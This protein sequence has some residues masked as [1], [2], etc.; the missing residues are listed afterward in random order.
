MSDTVQA[1]V[2]WGA[3]VIGGLTGNP[4][5]MLWGASQFLGVGTKR[6]FEPGTAPTAAE[7]ERGRQLNVLSNEAS[8]P[9]VYGRTRAGVQII[10]VRLH[11]SDTNILYVVAALALGSED[12]SGIEDV[13]E[14]YFDER[15]AISN[16]VF[17]SE[18]A[19]TGVQAPFTGKLS[20]GLHR[21]ADAQ[22][23]DAELDSVFSDYDADTVGRGIAY[24][25]LKLTYDTAVYPTGIPN[26][27]AVVKGQRVWDP[28]GTPA[29]AHSDS[30]AL[31]ILDYLTS[32]RYG[33][34]VLYGERDG[35]ASE[36]D[37]QSF[38]DAA[39]Y[40][41]DTITMGPGTGTRFTCNGLVDTGKTHG[42]VLTELLSSCRSE[43]IYEGGKFRL[44]TPQVTSPETFELNASNI[45]GEI[46]YWRGGTEDVPNRVI[47]H[48]IDDA[49][50]WLPQEVAWPEANQANGFLTA[51][52]NFE[53]VLE[54]A[55]PFTVG[56]YRAQQIGMVLLREA[57]E[58][59]GIQLTTREEGLKLRVGEVVRVTQSRAGF[60]QK[61]F[62]VRA[63][64][65]NADN[66]TRLVLAEYD[67]AAYTLDAQNTRDTLPASS[68]PDPFTIAAPTS[69]SATSGEATLLI[70]QGGAYIPRIQL[71]W[72]PPSTPFLRYYEVQLAVASSGNWRD[73]GTP[74]GLDSVVLVDGV[75]EGTAYD[76][77]IRAVNALDI[78]SAW[79]TVSSHTV[80]KT[81]AGITTLADNSG[82]ELGDRNWSKESGWA[83]AD[84]AANARR[85]S[86]R[87]A[88]TGGTGALRNS[89]EFLVDISQS[90]LIE[91]WIKGTVGADGDARARI[92][93]L[94]AS[95]VE[96]G[97]SPYTSV[98]ADGNYQKSSKV[99]TPPAGAVYGRAEFAV[100]TRTTG[101][102]YA[103]D[104]FCQPVEI[105][106][107]WVQATLTRE[108]LSE[109]ATLTL[110]VTDP[111]G[112]ITA[113][114]F[115]KR[116]GSQDGDVFGAYS[117][118][119]DT[120]PGSG[121]VGTYEEDLS[122]PGGEESAIAWRATFTDEHGTSRTIGGTCYTSQIDE[123]EP[124]LI[125][126][127]PEFQ[128]LTENAFWNFATGH[129]TP[130]AVAVPAQM[131]A[132]VVLPEGVEITEFRVRGF[133]NDTGD[134]GV[135]ELRRVN[136]TGTST[137]L[138]TLTLTQGGGW[139]LL[140]DTSLA[141]VVASPNIYIITAHLDSDD[142]V[143]NSRL[144]YASLTY[145]RRTMRQVV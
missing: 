46:E 113:V 56:H 17:E 66:T 12:G 1:V 59:T 128:G 68:L 96:I 20:Y 83:I 19:T 49:N 84:D 130:S 107:P 69:L 117:N 6:L 97:T 27:T 78:P 54:V 111:S 8:I 18:P 62:R 104:V 58:D 9:V 85:G 79:A 94:N 88:F 22:T 124:T 16:P 43:L 103:D 63:I 109:T 55:L 101:T 15:L 4:G 32:K 134:T 11:P 110:V 135:F 72:T 67:A 5:L 120:A 123:N 41:D 133:S 112:R 2:G 47:C 31:C 33:C 76:V 34:G 39:N 7:R 99:V 74:G 21:G 37:E 45:I 81:P 115:S 73:A 116:E 26:I 40:H 52:N 132:P 95:R 136:N 86:W 77:R 51:D 14:I 105:R 3:F 143:L 144:A 60:A 24:M 92:S 10:D 108:D 131:V 44:V 35:G 57:R 139:Q 64:G 53:N 122:V 38:I 100:S 70:T 89:R 42:T 114:E 87:A 106:E 61:E 65:L 118:A 140:A 138:A 90:Y 121:F 142:S 98:T 93:W 23:V 25:V 50:A 129:L 80:A 82:F 48:Y 125:I 119:W 102:W 141:E 145:I 28:R 127:A 36:I 29:W 91:G 75:Q 126:A 13:D 71:S 30:P 137:L